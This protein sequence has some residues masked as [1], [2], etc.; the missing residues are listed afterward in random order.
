MV[1][2]VFCKFELEREV[3]L[4][5]MLAQWPLGRMY[6]MGEARHALEHTKIG[7]YESLMYV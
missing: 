4:L 3:F 6:S 5:R 1:V 2:V 7:L